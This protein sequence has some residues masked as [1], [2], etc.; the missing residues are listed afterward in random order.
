MNL[1][2]LMTRYTT[3]TLILSPFYSKSLFGD[4]DKKLSEVG[5]INIFL[6]YGDRAKDSTNGSIAY[7]SILTRGFLEC[8]LAFKINEYYVKH[9]EIDDEITLVEMKLPIPGMK[10]TVLQGKYSELREAGYHKMVLK[11]SIAYKIVT[12]DED[13][14]R[15]WRLVEEELNTN[16]LEGSEVFPKPN[17]RQ[18]TFLLRTKE[19]TT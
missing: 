17:Y 9:R 8:E 5:L 15:K 6:L 13:I 16:I 18:E 4:S 19:L 12:Q 11:E 10:R 1:L 14:G 3:G 2:K 7:L